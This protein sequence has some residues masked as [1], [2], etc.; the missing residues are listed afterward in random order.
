MVDTL[1]IWT[2]LAF[3][4]QQN[5][6]SK[7]YRSKKFANI[8]HTQVTTL[9]PMKHACTSNNF[10]E[11]YITSTISTFK[12]AIVYSIL[13]IRDNSEPKSIKF[14]QKAF[15]AHTFSKTWLMLKVEDIFY[16]PL[17]FSCIQFL[18]CHNSLLLHS[19]HLRSRVHNPTLL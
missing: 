1:E 15:I 14:Q 11:I 7:F 12:Y 4:W 17:Q 2:I 19:K 10:T 3:L 8:H 6:K 13:Y 16:Q 9:N 18:L 5:W